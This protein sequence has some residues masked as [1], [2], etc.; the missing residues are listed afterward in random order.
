MS[1]PPELSLDMMAS[2]KL[3]TQSPEPAVSLINIEVPASDPSWLFVPQVNTET[4]AKSSKVDMVSAAT[5]DLANP[6]ASESVSLENAASST[7]L[8]DPTATRVKVEGSEA[9]EEDDHRVEDF[10]EEDDLAVGQNRNKGTPQDQTTSK[11]NIVSN[12]A[13]VG[14]NF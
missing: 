3:S 12:S 11:T 6:T 13:R 8:A 9:Q 4:G 5:T 1:L 14:F 7:I 2:E 10:D